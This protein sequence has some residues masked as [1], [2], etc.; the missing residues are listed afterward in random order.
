M[1][2]GIH[3]IK[4]T[5]IP[6]IVL[7]IIALVVFF[8]TLY[9]EM[10]GR[11]VNFSDPTV[12]L[13]MVV[14]LFAGIILLA[15]S[16]VIGVDNRSEFIITLVM[17]GLHL[18]FDTYIFAR[19]FIF[20]Q[21]LP[22]ALVQGVVQAYWIAGLFDVLLMYLAANWERTKPDYVDPFEQLKV[23]AMDLEHKLEMAQQQLAN[24]LSNHEAQ[25][26]NLTAAHEN[27]LSNL[28]DTIENLKETIKK[29]DDTIEKLR[30]DLREA[31]AE[32]HRKH[33]WTCPDCGKFIE[34][35]SASSL[36]RA[37]TVH[38]AQWCKGPKAD[39]RSNGHKHA[40]TLTADA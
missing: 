14:F 9:F 15:S 12:A 8:T 36:E 28:T 4:R 18:L 11:P 25:V 17:I 32:A 34:H 6:R 5:H 2:T 13:G 40:S 35:D 10:I 1:N 30:Q 23:R 16:F 3:N 37:K 29:R 31:K 27:A 19:V 38:L 22:V 33:T 26:Q 7:A 21:T 39:A 20:R 24:A